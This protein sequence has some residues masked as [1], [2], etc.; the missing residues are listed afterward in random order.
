LRVLRGMRR[1]VPYLSF[2]VNLPEFKQEGLQ[3][4]GVLGDSATGEFNYAADCKRGLV[5]ERWVDRQQFSQV[6]DRCTERCIE[7]FCR[8]SQARGM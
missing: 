7:V 5:L 4:L 3:C 1:R 6:F 2:E 8:T